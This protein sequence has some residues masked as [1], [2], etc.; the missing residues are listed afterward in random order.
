M[1]RTL[2]DLIQ[3]MEEM[4]SSEQFNPWDEQQTRSLK[5][6][7]SHVKEMRESNSRYS[8][9]TKDVTVFGFESST[10]YGYSQIHYVMF[11]KNECNCMNCSVGETSYMEG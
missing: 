2:D 11:Y 3:E 1:R 10:K 5:A 6:M 8:K 7:R 9:L 4:E